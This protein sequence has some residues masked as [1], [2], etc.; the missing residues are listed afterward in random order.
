MNV[1][2]PTLRTRTVVVDSE[3]HHFEIAGVRGWETAESYGDLVVYGPD[4]QPLASF[5]HW[6]SIVAKP[7]TP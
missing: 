3:G 7:V 1:T 6:D 2:E 4:H 5:R